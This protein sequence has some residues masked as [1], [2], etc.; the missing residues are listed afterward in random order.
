[1]FV[2]LPVKTR[3]ENDS[4]LKDIENLR[5]LMIKVAF[6]EGLTSINTIKLSRRLDFL[7]NKYQR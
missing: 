3:V 2:D 7:L 6:E 5:Q 4:L 1:M